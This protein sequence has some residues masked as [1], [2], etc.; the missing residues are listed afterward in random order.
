MLLG[1]GAK[2]FWTFGYKSWQCGQTSVRCAQRHFLRKILFYKKKELSSF[3]NIEP[4]TFKKWQTFCCVLWTPNYVTRGFSSENFLEVRLAILSHSDL[5]K[6][7]SERLSKLLSMNA[8]DRFERKKFFSKT[9]FHVFRIWIKQF[10]DFW[11]KK[12]FGRVAE[13]PLEEPGGTFWER[14]FF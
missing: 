11:Q 9:F 3:S 8:E 4:N 2:F 13:V 7:N 1:L 5:W 10:L 14:C 6:K 12:K